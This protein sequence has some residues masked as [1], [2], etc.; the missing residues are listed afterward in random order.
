MIDFRTFHDRS[1]ATFRPCPTPAREPDFVSPSGSAYWDEIR[2]VIRASDHWA[3]QNGCSGQASC[4]WELSAPIAPG[5]WA[6]GICAYADFRRRERIRVWHELTDRDREAAVFLEA[7]GGALPFPAWVART[8]AM[9]VP[10]WARKVFPGPVLIPESA[11]RL[12]AVTPGLRHAV[13]AEPAA[14]DVIL[15]GEDRVA[16]GFAL[17]S[18]ISFRIFARSGDLLR[19]IGEGQMPVEECLRRLGQKYHL[20]APNCWSLIRKGRLLGS[21]HLQAGPGYLDLEL[22]IVQKAHRGS[23]IGAEMIADLCAAADAEAVELLLSVVGASAKDDSRLVDWYGRKGFVEAPDL[24]FGDD[25]VM[26]RL[27]APAVAIA[28]PESACPQIAYPESED[29]EMA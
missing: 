15:S 12:F 8:G 17:S 10:P 4:V 21:L 27:P 1:I 22:I 16:I 18:R 2:A 7:A 3:G 20:T 9:P 6:T 24:C 14:L 5:A 19:D 11:R 29:F 25:Y 28:G 13:A 26:R 23:G